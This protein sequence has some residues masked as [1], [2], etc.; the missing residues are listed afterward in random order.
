MLRK[1]EFHFCHTNSPYS[2]NDKKSPQYCWINP[3]KPLQNCQRIEIAEPL[4]NHWNKRGIAQFNTNRKDLWEQSVDLM[5]LPIINKLIEKYGR[6]RNIF[7]KI[8][9]AKFLFFKKSSYLCSR[10]FCKSILKFNELYNILIINNL[11]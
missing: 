7:F 11:Q 10:N 1:L 9:P 4:Q 8:H 5:L 3:K 6:I 2:S